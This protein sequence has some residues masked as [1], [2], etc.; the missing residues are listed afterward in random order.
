LRA[1][2]NTTL[3]DI[4][5]LNTRTTNLQNDVFVF[6]A[7]ITGRVFLDANGD[8]QLNSGE[9]Q[10]AG[11]LVQLIDSSGNIVASTHT[12]SNGSYQFDDLALGTYRVR[13]APVP[14]LHSTTGDPVKVQLTRG[15]T[16][17]E[18]FG[19]AHKAQP[20]PTTPTP[21]AAAALGAGPQASLPSGAADQSLAA[22]DASR[23]A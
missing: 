8:G 3:A 18:N 6:D 2:Q 14:G 10:L 1:I 9:Q 19:F 12:A 22:P 7:T 21:T 17:M 4:I 11:M 16:V 23:S 15:G 20:K 13:V 5:R